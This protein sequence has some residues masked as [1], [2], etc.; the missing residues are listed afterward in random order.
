MTIWP[1]ISLACAIWAASTAIAGAFDLQ[2]HRGGRGLTPES[3]LAGFR[4]AIALGVTTI[5]TDLAVTRDDVL[6]LSHEPRLNPDLVRGPDGKWIEGPGPTIHSL[7][8]AELETYDIG[9]LN[10][11]TRYGRQFPMQTPSDGERFPTLAGLYAM[12]GPDVRF[13]IETKVDPT[14]PDETVDPVRFTRLV[15]DAIR[16]AKTERRTTIQSFDWR[17]LIEAHRIAPEIA[18][19]C[20]TIE[21]NSM[22]TVRGPNGQ[23]SPWLGGLDLAA[24]GGSIVALARQAGCS[25]WS[26]FWRNVTAA[27]VAE[28]HALGLKVVPWTVNAPADMAMLIDLKVDGLITDYPDRGLAVLAE[29]GLKP[30]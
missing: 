7:T 16:A 2:A 22:N 4:N 30:R 8:L 26:P 24:A 19:A 29:K 1:A 20:L 5:E 17:T 15:V 11:A 9:R 6:V 21:S 12:A 13:N 18:T 14:R 25:V 23:P 10:P 27:N 3:T 28:A